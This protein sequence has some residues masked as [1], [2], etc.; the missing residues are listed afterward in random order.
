[1]QPQQ[2]L[3]DPIVAIT[4]N[5]QRKHPPI[6]FAVCVFLEVREKA[7]CLSAPDVMWAFAWCLISQN[8]IPG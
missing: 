5:G 8:I 6:Y 7:Q 3:C 1:M 4:S 2:M